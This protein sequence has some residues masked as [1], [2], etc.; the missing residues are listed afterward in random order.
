[1]QSARGGRPGPPIISVVIPEAY[2]IPA[3]LVLAIGGLLACFAGFRL[4]RVVLALYGFVIGA[5]LTTGILGAPDPW[6]LTMGVIVGGVVGTVLAIL[7]YYLG[8]GLI[9][10]GLGVLILHLFWRLV[11]GEPPTLALVIM[12][13]VG[14]LIALTTARIVV[15][16]GTALA[17]SWTLIVGALGLLGDPAGLR[18]ASVGDVWSMY[19]FDPDDGRVWLAGVWLILAL[20]GV[21]VQLATSRRKRPTM[22][23]AAR[24]QR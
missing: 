16:F 18:A 3:A 21:V 11:G 19:P 7:A 17:G 9:G 24:S 4:F 14:A 5:V 22:G 1:V 2:V 10:A 23:P 8:V 12:A 15:I 20:A 6:T 13:V